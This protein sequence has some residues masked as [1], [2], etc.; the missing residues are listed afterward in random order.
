MKRM[1]FHLSPYPSTKISIRNIHSTIRRKYQTILHAQPQI[2]PSAINYQ[3][4]KLQTATHRSRGLYSKLFAFGIRHPLL[5]ATTFGTL[6]S[7]FSDV[8]AQCGIEQ[9]D[10]NTFNWSRFTLFTLFGVFYVGM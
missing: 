10:R 6:K 8:L 7:V 9:R 2:P 3:I 5:L 1:G 4:T